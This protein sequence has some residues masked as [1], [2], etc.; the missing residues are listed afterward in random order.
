MTIELAFHQVDVF[1][2]SPF[3]GNP[4]AVVVGADGL[5]DVQ[6]T[7]IANWTNLSE[8]TFLLKPTHPDADYRVRIF[9]PQSELPFAG[10]P[11]LGTAHVWLTCGGVPRGSVVVQE[12]PAGL[13]RVRTDGGRVAFAAPPLVRSGSVEPADLLKAMAALRLAPEAVVAARWC[14]N[15]PGWLG[16]QLRSRAEVLS[17]RPNY[18]ALVG[19]NLGVV[20]AWDPAF[21]GSE[22]QFELRAFVG[23][24]NGFED[25]VTGSLNASIAQWLIGAGIAPAQY[26][27][28]QGTAMGREGR[29]ILEQSGSDIWVGGRVVTRISGIIRTE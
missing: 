23:A 20:G 18:Q 10:H 11:T 2:A 29:V 24:E 9:T 1:A 5:T 21:D 19:Q 15:G 26:V 3:K 14:D 22:A 8:T 28:S 17:I 27:A 4:L 6:M 12:C 16:V 25:P 13:V 7:V